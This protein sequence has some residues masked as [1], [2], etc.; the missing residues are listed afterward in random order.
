MTKSGSRILRIGIVAVLLA[1]CGG[2]ADDP[3]RVAK[4]FL[5]AWRVGNREAAA[6]A[7]HPDSRQLFAV[8]FQSDDVE[9]RSFKLGTPVIRGDDAWVPYTELDATFSGEKASLPAWIHLRKHGGEWRV[10]NPG[11]P[12]P[13]EG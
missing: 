10:V 4:A 7:V 11:G 13:P 3:A 6:H 9:I 12:G 5:H 8:S 2:G 1:G